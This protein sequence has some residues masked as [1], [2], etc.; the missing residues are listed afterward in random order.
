LNAGVAVDPILWDQA[1]R[2]RAG[3]VSLTIGSDNL[4]TVSGPSE[5]FRVL[6]RPSADIDLNKPIL[7]RYGS[8]TKRVEFDGSLEHLMEDVRQRADRNRAFWTS[9]DIP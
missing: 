9:V 3:K 1:E 2:L 7:V 6:L 4:I 5:T 8:R